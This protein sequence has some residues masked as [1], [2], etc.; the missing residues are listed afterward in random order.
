MKR[1]YP[2]IEHETEKDLFE[3]VLL[4]EPPGKIDF[5]TYE[6]GYPKKKVTYELG[7]MDGRAGIIWQEKPEI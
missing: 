1:Q 6:R 7:K 2:G 5:Q 3:G 4:P